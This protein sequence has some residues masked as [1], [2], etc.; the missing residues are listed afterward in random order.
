MCN[1]WVYVMCY[2]HRSTYNYYPSFSLLGLMKYNNTIDN[3]LEQTINKW[4]FSLSI[5]W[6]CLG[7]S[8]ALAV[9]WKAWAPRW[10][11]FQSWWSRPST[12]AGRPWWAA[13][14]C[15][16]SAGWAHHQQS[17]GRSCSRWPTERQSAGQT[18]QKKWCTVCQTVHSMWAPKLNWLRPLNLN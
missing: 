11:C 18:G 10:P 17:P 15:V 1:M 8:G 9:V 7:P 14:A 12:E 4:S 16:S 2:Y 5:R 3:R 13:A 6:P